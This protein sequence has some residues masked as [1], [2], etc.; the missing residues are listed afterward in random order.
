M[1]MVRRN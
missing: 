1:K